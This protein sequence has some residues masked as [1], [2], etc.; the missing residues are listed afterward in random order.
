MA[1]KHIKP[2]KAWSYKDWEPPF[3]W[4]FLQHINLSI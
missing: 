2:I 4:D 3:L 1:Q